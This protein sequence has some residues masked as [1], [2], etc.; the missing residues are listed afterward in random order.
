MVG[1][2]IVVLGGGEV[3]EGM[4]GEG[5]GRDGEGWGGMVRDGIRG[6]GG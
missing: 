5:M 2:G 6:G 3:G 4:V 1:D